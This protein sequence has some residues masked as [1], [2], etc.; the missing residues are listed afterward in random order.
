MLPAQAVKHHDTATHILSADILKYL[1]EVSRIALAFFEVNV[2]PLCSS[3]LRRSGNGL[4]Q[5]QMAGSKSSDDQRLNFI[6]SSLLNSDPRVEITTDRIRGS[7]DNRTAEVF[8]AF[9]KPLA[10][11]YDS[12]CLRKRFIFGVRFVITRR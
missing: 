8:F 11:A 10:W 1:E 2:H 3:G 7:R 4:L 5:F 12:G 9:S 6:S